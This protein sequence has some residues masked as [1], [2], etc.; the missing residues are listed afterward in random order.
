MPK[1]WLTPPEMYAALDT[2]FGFDFDPC[3]C[4]L[5]EGHDGLSVPWGRMSYVNPPFRRHD[6]PYGT[7]GPTAFAHKAI[8]EHRVHGRGAVLVLPVP[9]YVMHLEAAGAEI[10]SMGRVR[11]LDTETREPM[12][13]PSPICAFILKPGGPTNA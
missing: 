5:P 10:R 2:E 3:P 6:N 4:P 8:A 7:G 11:W 12:K 13:G 1:Y 9:S